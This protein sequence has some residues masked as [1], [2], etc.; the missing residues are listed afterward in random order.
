[1]LI[2]VWLLRRNWQAR[3]DAGF[4]FPCVIGLNA[5]ADAAM[6]SLGRT[7]FGTNQALSSRYTTIAEPLWIAIVLLVVLDLVRRGGPARILPLSRLLLSVATTVLLAIASTAA[8][9]GLHAAD[10]R[11]GHLRPLRTML[12]DGVNWPAL[13][14]LYIGGGQVVRERAGQLRML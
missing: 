13:A 9:Q 11:M 6:T 8:L 10:E 1:V 3:R 12:R 2:F 14:T 7:G 5:I 4:I